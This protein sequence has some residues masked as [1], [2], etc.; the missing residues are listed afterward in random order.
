VPSALAKKTNQAEIVRSFPIV[1]GSKMIFLGPRRDGSRGAR[2][3]ILV[4]IL[5][6]FA[7]GVVIVAALAKTRDTGGIVPR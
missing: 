4:L 6:V 7:L 5:A 1:E 3:A 2:S